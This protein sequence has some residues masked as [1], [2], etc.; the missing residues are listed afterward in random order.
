MLSL[1]RTIRSGIQCPA[2]SDNRLRLHADESQLRHRF[3]RAAAGR[4]SHAAGE[5][6]LCGVRLRVLPRCHAHAKRRSHGPDAV[7]SRRL[8]YQR[9]PIV[10][11]LRAGIP[12]TAKLSPMPQFSDLSDRQLHDIARYIHYARQQGRYKEIVEAKAGPGDAAAGVR[13]FAQN[14]ASCHAADLNGIGKNTTRP[15]SGTSC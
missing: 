3:H 2:S 6:N 10:A 11:L 7:G 5:G 14:C 12:Q 8:R 15:R 13:Y 9:R 1:L 4:S